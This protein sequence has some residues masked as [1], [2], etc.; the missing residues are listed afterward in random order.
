MLQKE[1]R[2][3]GI[4]RTAK[5][6]GRCVHKRAAAVVRKVVVRPNAREA[7]GETRDSWD[8]G[9]PGSLGGVVVSKVVELPQ[10]A[11]ACA[12]ELTKTKFAVER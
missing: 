7:F 8:P 5:P 4:A 10:L 9:S 3:N 2:E 12:H 6:P 1:L 11:D